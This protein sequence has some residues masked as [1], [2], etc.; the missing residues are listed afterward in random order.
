MN[1]LISGDVDRR[2][3]RT[4]AD[5][6]KEYGIEGEIYAFDAQ[7]NLVASS[8]ANAMT[9][10][11]P[12]IWLSPGKDV[13]FIDKHV[14]PLAQGQVVALTVGMSARFGAGFK[15]GT[16]IV[17]LPW[18]TVEKMLDSGDQRILLYRDEPP[19]FLYASHAGASMNAADILML[20]NRPAEPVISS[21]RYVAGYSQLYSALLKDWHIAALKEAS[22]ADQP[23]R[24]VAFELLILGLILSLPI[25]L[26]IRWLS[27]RLT[28]PIESL[29]RVVGSVTGSGDL[30]ARVEIQ[31]M[32]EL[33]TLAQAFNGMAENLQRISREREM[34]VTALEQLNVTLEQRVQERTSALEYTNTEL[35][36]AI[37][38]LKAAQ[39]QL[40]QS[41]KMASLGQLVA[42]VAHE[43]NNPISF[44]YANFPHLEEHAAALLGL[45]EEMRKLPMDQ[46]HSI[47]IE[48]KI[49]QIDLEYL[50]EDIVK[51]IRSGKSGAARIKEIVSSLRSFSRL[52]EADWKSVVLED[53]ID[54]TLSILQHHIKNRV[55]VIKDYQLKTP[56]LCRAGQI[57]QVFMNVLYNAIQAIE[58]NGTIWIS[59]RQ[60]GEFA[61][62]AIRDSGKGV[63][64]ELIGKIFDPFFTTKRVGEGTGLGLSISYG[65]VEKHGG[66]MEVSSAVGKGST[67]TIYIRMKGAGEPGTDSGNS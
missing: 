42:G 14:D 18:K 60:E 57:N 32:D 44:I 50:R 49:A 63:P 26:A 48:K 20:A 65:I 30:S 29:T 22:V 7:D 23:I 24:T 34:F 46:A 5:L 31:S 45:I 53:G 12:P 8:S 61:A 2:I 54:D 35:S 43:L 21:T 4:L 13:A 19:M 3:A 52:D 56:V 58:G 9:A 11:L 47:A 16:L 25:V 38:H 37:D 51:I 15:I 6:K 62:I 27:R 28:D 41:E 17:T 40:V 64:A 1:D 36:Q 59:T 66:H 67:F 55:E 33:G 10:S 39:I